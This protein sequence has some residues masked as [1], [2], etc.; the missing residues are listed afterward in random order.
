[1]NENKLLLLAWVGHDVSSISEGS[2]RVQTFVNEMI[3][4]G[5]FELV[6]YER[7]K[8]RIEL[9]PLGERL[10]VDTIKYMARRC[11]KL[12]EKYDD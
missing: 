3:K 4:E 5:I 2:P 1:M 7:Y 6:N 12:K 10:K 11:A 8:T 9:T